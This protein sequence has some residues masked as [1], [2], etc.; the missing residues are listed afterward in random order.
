MDGKLDDWADAQWVTVDKRSESQGDWGRS[1]AKAQAA[2]AISGDRLYAAFKTG[3][4]DLLRN[5][6]SNRPLLFKTGGALDLSWTPC[7]AASA[8]W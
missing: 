4:R 1:E 5:D 8:C 2:L 7:P 6:G 3:D